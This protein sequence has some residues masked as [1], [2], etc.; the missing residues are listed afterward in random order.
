MKLTRDRSLEQQKFLP[1]LTRHT[2]IV[3]IGTLTV[4]SALILADIFYLQYPLVTQTGDANLQRWIGPGAVKIVGILLGLLFGG[5]YLAVAIRGT[6]EVAT[7][8]T[9][10]LGAV[11]GV[12]L[13]MVVLLLYAITGLITISLGELQIPIVAL[14]GFILVG[15]PIVGFI[16][17]EGECRISA[18]AIAGFWFGAMLALVAGVSI[19]A[20]DVLFA[21]HL[22]L[23]VWSSDNFGD[24]LC[25][26]AQ[27]SILMVCEVGDDLGFTAN[28]FLLLPLLGLLLGTG[29]GV[30]GRIS[31]RRKTA[32]TAHWNNALAAPLICMGFLLIIFI[33]EAIWNL[34]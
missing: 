10:K 11:A 18:G 19:L 20:R 29:G 23:T 25:R 3:A 1:F 34:W 12:G 13:G 7:A 5:C 4:L 26:G 28:A 31:T 14:Y 32:L 27:G 9:W 21:Q 22:A 8:W 33:A 17:G 2:L 24:S 15:P 16:A 30:L 6:R